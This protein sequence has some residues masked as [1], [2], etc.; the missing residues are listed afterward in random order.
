VAAQIKKLTANLQRYDGEKADVQAKAQGFE[1]QRDIA[2]ARGGRM[3]LAVSLLSVSIATASI[4]TVTKKKPL[5]FVAIVMA[6]I[7]TAEM[8]AAWLS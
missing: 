4:C 3:G 2:S 5:W 1:K 8:V 7:A 6:T